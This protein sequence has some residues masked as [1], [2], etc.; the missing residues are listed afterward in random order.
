MSKI[1]NT[2]H[3]TSD[4]QYPI[5][6]MRAVRWALDVGCWVLGVQRGVLQ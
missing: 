6:G 5:N 4:I 3:P 2:Q 1:E